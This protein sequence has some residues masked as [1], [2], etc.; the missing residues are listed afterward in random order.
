MTYLQALHAMQAGVAHK[1]QL[2]PSETTPKHLRVGVNAAMCNHA[3]LVEL[4]IEKGI[5]TLA[6]YKA[7]ITAEANREVAR[8]EADLSE[9]LGTRVRLCASAD[10]L[11]RTPPSG[12]Q[13]GPDA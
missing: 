12:K 4:L 11:G 6:E 13:G 1:M 7:A 2:D 9:R 3:A 8:Y 5:F 10:P